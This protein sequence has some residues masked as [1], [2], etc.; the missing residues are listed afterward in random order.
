MQ[1]GGGGWTE[2]KDKEIIEISEPGGG[3]GVGCERPTGKK[4][5]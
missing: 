4:S 3:G 5:S 1:V 2:V